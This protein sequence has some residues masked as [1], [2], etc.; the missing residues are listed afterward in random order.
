MKCRAAIL[1]CLTCICF[2]LVPA[3]AA[4]AGSG[5]SDATNAA[6][7][8]KA[9]RFEANTQPPQQAIIRITSLLERHRLGRYKGD[10]RLLLARSYARYGLPGRAA[11]I[12][13]GLHKQN[14]LSEHISN[15]TWLALARQRFEKGD[16]GSADR[17]LQHMAGALSPRMAMHLRDLRGRILLARRQYEMAA[18]MFA[19]VYVQTS[20]VDSPDARFRQY[21]RAVAYMRAGHEKLAL[22]LLNALGTLRVPQGNKVLAALRDRA[23]LVLG[24]HFLDDGRG[25]NAEAVLKR[26]RLQ[27]PFSNRALLAMGW[28]ELAPRGKAAQRATLVVAP[29]KHKIPEV[30]SVLRRP[31]PNICTRPSRVDK[32]LQSFARSKDEDNSH[33]AALRRALVP[34][35][36]LASRSMAAPSVQEA[37]LA[38]GYALESLHD[39]RGAIQAYRRAIGKL[40]SETSDQASAIHAF[41]DKAIMKTLLS[42][43]PARS[44]QGHTDR[45]ATLS[46]VPQARYLPQLL[47]DDTFQRALGAYRDLSVL[48][49]KTANTAPAAIRHRLH[50]LMAQ[51]AKLLRQLAVARLQRD[52][53]LTTRYLGAARLGLARLS[54]EALQEGGP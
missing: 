39:N 42:T 2:S 44:G 26:I 13:H 9:I 1:A 8:Y 14:N 10:A 15:Q 25:A 33:E 27:G 19:P 40:K 52:R 11:R 21:N 46:S 47:A 20:P 50:H 31:R 16:T 12:L 24:Y 28:A 32:V 3:L 41:R 48:G 17:A 29:C 30:A 34:W 45:S 7:Y 5:G 4:A 18:R 23:N 49:N 22:G 36:A 37:S 51:N 35:R 54:N 38:I 53:K 43:V 6:L